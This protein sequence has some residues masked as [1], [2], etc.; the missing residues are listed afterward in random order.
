MRSQEFVDALGGTAHM[1]PAE[2]H[3]RALATTSHLPQILATLLANQAANRSLTGTGY[4]DMTRLAASDV[5]IWREILLSNRENIVRAMDAY[6]DSF[7]RF[8]EAIASGDVENID[9]WL[10][11]G[12]QGVA[13]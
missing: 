4:R 5:S 6:R 3:D 8:G 12:R 1:M 10:R 11:R 7:D 9:A 13:A 2:E